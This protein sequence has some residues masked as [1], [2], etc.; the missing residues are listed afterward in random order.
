ME[1]AELINISVNG[2][3][4]SLKRS[5]FDINFAEAD[6]T[7]KLVEGVNEIVYSLNFYQHE[8][9]HFALFDPM[10]TES[11]KNCLYFDTSV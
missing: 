4:I 8:G 3:N 11:L 6:I 5:S 10:S 9:V 7:D 2:I 1:K